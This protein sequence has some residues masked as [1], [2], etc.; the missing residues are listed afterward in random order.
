MG[1][2]HFNFQLAGRDSDDFVVLERRPGSLPASCRQIRSLDIYA[3]GLAGEAD[4]SWSTNSPRATLW[5]I[6]AAL[7]GFVAMMK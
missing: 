4:P 3:G 2:R 6:P 1:D 5:P 7:E